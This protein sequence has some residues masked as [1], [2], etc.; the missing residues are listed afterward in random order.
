MTHD[1]VGVIIIEEG[2]KAWKVIQERYQSVE[3]PAVVTLVALLVRLQLEDSEDLDGF[4]IRG[5]GLLTRLQEAGELVS[6]NPF[7]ALLL[8]GLPM[9]YKSFVIQENL[10]PA[11]T[12]TEKGKGCRISMRAQHRCAR[13]KVVQWLRQ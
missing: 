2:A 12:F 4:L 8:K 6:D 1:S 9:R 5:Q 7:N 13:D 10:N 3:T 11:T